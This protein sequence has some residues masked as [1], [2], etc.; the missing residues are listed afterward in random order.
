MVRIE[1]KNHLLSQCIKTTNS[2]QLE[3]G[4][5]EQWSKKH[6]GDLGEFKQT[7]LQFYYWKEKI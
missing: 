7:L 3:Q 6:S 1:V 5:R 4:A 2:Q